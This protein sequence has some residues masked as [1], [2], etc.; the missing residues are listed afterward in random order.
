M[1]NAPTKNERFKTKEGRTGRRGGESSGQVFWVVINLDR[2]GVGESHV[3]AG[4]SCP[5][6]VS[7]FAE[8]ESQGGVV[9]E[10]SQ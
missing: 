5:R 9:C 8:G 1:E 2:G 3:G 7:S 6:V 4:H 10:V